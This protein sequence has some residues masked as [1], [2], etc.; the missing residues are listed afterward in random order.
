[1]RARRPRPY[2]SRRSP[3]CLR[4]FGVMGR[5]VAPG[6]TLLAGTA[7]LTAIA[8]RGVAQAPQLTAAAAVAVL[9]IAVALVVPARVVIAAGL[10]YLPFEA[11]II[12]FLP[13][14]VSSVARYG[15]EAIGAVLLTWRLPPSA[16]RTTAGV[17]SLSPASSW[18]SCGPSRRC[19]GAWHPVPR[20]SGTAPNFAGCPSRSSS[21]SAATIRSTPAGT[22]GPCWVQQPSRA[23]SQ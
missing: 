7:A 20:S 14:S 16:S 12:G 2:R 9:A 11:W 10:V 19:T 5:Q 18:S 6:V 8:A 3:R 15:P 4:E 17:D 1:M 22:D 21:H 13:G 23:S